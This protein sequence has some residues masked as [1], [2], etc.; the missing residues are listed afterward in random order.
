MEAPQWLLTALND[1]KPITD[2]AQAISKFTEHVS[3][4]L[5][6]TDDLATKAIEVGRAL[7]DFA[8]DIAGNVEAN[9][10]VGAPAPTSA[11]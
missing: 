3:T 9:T 4:E 1:I 7:V 5:A 6:S 10:P 2:K 8:E 11:A